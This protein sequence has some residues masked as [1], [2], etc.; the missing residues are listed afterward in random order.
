ME[1]FLRPAV[2]QDAKYQ[3]I[4]QTIY[5]EVLWEFENYRFLSILPNE[6]QINNAI[7][8]PKN[9]K[10]RPYKRTL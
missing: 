10:R 4:K 6:I 9:G 1:N 2:Q 7:K 5:T 8:L 3:S